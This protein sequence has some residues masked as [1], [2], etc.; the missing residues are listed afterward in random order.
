VGLVIGESIIAS[1][2]TLSHLSLREE[3]G[4]LVT[5]HGVGH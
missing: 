5:S 2:G 1:L 4:F 3:D